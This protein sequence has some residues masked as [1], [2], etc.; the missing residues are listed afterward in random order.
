MDA[1]LVRLGSASFK[2]YKKQANFDAAAALMTFWPIQ[3]TPL[4]QF[5]NNQSPIWYP[6]Q[7]SWEDNQLGGCTLGCATAFTEQAVGITLNLSFNYDKNDK[8]TG[9]AISWAPDP[10]A[11]FIGPNPPATATTLSM[12]PGGLTPMPQA[13]RVDVN[14]SALRNLSP[15]QLQALATAA[16]NVPVAAVR[17]ALTQ[18]ISREQKRRADEQKKKKPCQSGESDCSSSN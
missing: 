2:V 6:T 11:S 12:M 9:A 7:V 15:Q 18:A 4:N 1:G 14:S 3:H 8:L 10:S 17:Q 5:R 16:G 13:M